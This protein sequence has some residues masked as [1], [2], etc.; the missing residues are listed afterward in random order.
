MDGLWPMRKS[1]LFY[2][3]YVEMIITLDATD[4]SLEIASDISEYYYS[5]N[6][7]AVKKHIIYM[8]TDNI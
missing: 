1:L 3:Q 4:F 6:K 8:S 5:S 7:F 2:I